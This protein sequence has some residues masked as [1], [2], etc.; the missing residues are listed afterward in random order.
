MGETTPEDNQTPEKSFTNEDV[1]R[2]VKER[3]A[4]AKKKEAEKFADYDDLKKAAARLAELE[5]GQKTEIEKAIARAEK[6][7]K[8]R[9]DLSGK[10]ET[11]KSRQEVRTKAKGL[12]EKA[13]IRSEGWEIM[14]DL[15]SAD[16]TEDKLA[17]KLEKVKRAVG[18][19]SV[20]G[21]GRNVV[22]PKPGEKTIDDEIKELETARMVAIQNHDP[23]TAGKLSSEIIH[24]KLKRKEALSNV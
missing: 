17:A 11:W 2:I 21:S 7:E 23:V 8:E 10:I 15:I 13:G 22:P 9:D 1:E 20:G 14:E 4:T 24:R 12:F 16:D 19:R 18:I 3:I 6:A 5:A